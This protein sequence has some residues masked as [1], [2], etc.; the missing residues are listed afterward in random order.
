MKLMRSRAH[1]QPEATKLIEASKQDAIA[2]SDGRQLMHAEYAAAVL[3]NGLGRYEDAL[4][5]VRPACER[6]EFFSCWLLPELIEA[7]ARSGRRELALTAC[8]QLAR[9]T[10]IGN[11]EWALGIEARS[12][13]LVTE[14]PKAEKR[15]REAIE[16]LAR[17]PAAAH[18]A[19]AH[20]VYGEWLR[21]QRRRVEAREQ[22]RLAEEM[23]AGMGA[24]AFAARAHRE[25][26]ATGEHARKRTVETT[27]ELTA[28]EAQI[29]RLA[30]HGHS[31]PQIAARLFISAR[32][33][34]YHLHKVFTKLGISSRIQLTEVLHVDTSNAV[35][36]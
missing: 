18:L 22:L 1:S 30:G 34:E 11:T 2:R 21:R 12:V 31:N 9:Q 23:F 15:Y 6:E 32:T 35:S 14:G 28:Q 24:A 3:Y 20:L 10:Q 19:R 13:A 4:S 5:A 7:A 8:D 29:A 17:C 33:V 25:L 16:R 36:E 27:S 26:L